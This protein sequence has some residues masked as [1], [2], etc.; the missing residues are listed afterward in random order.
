V[1]FE[2]CL[3]GKPTK[4]PYGGGTVK[5]EFESA[6]FS[7]ELVCYVSGAQ[8]ALHFG[9]R[10]FSWNFIRWRHRAYSIV[11][12]A[13]LNEREAPGKV[14]TARP[15]KHLAQLRSVSHVLFSTL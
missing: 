14:V 5:W 10:Q 4:P 2:L 7:T 12:R 6:L 15:P 3:G 8:P 9:E 1:A 13:G 11:V